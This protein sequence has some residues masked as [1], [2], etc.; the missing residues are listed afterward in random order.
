VAAGSVVIQDVL[1]NQVVAG[2]PARFVKMKD[3][4]TKGKTGLVDA[5]RSL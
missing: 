1:E 4:K 5:L 2:V 3:D